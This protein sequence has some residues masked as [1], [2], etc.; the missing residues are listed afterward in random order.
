MSTKFD[1]FI[2]LAAMRTGSNLL[3][4][5]LNALDGVACHGEAFNP[6]F[7]GR[8]K[9]DELFGVSLEERDK[10]PMRL[11]DA[12]RAAP[13]ALNGFR[14]FQEHDPRVLQS[15]LDDPRC[16][17]IILSRN[18]LD[19]YVSLKI[20]RKTKQWQLTNIK[21]RKDAQIE[22][23]PVDFASY[24]DEQQE[25]KQ[26][27]QIHLQKTGQTAFHINYDDLNQLEILNGLSAWLG[28]GSRLDA[29]DDRLKPQNPAPAL[30]KVTNP[31]EMENALSKIDSF[32]LHRVPNFEPRRGPAVSRYI[33]APKTPLMYLPIR[34]GPEAV[35]AQWL[36]DLDT[37][38][39]RDLLTD[40]NRKQMR[41]WM[42]TNPGHRKFT[43]LRHPLARA[44][45]VFCSHILNKG[46]GAY[47]NIRNML[48][49]KYKIPFPGQ[50][51]KNNYS[52]EQHY[53]AFSAFLVFL[54]HI[55]AGQTPIRVDGLWCSQAS[56]LEGMSVFAMPDFILR[57]EEIETALPELARK[58]GHTNPPILG[59]SEADV[60]FLLPDIYDAELEA[61]ATE[62]YQRDYVLY[63]FKD[64]KPL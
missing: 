21:V 43:V 41:Q 1:Y 56:T 15:A 52:K 17:K 9:S 46:P 59:T 42:Q 60:P 40:R 24:L 33:A 10:D 3:E 5:N 28:V 19:S 55:L 63:G 39:A 23:D 36:A 35:V 50:I 27:L 48:R 49:N 32:N 44:H 54:R 51:R 8:L 30:S 20:A 38:D 47:L 4:A 31:V 16:A 18:P 2:V 25:F 37:M 45:S 64:W 14:Y 57:E 29:L 34:G 13:D 12:I 62:T 11:L 7:I 61:L 53:E 6:H 26:M 58:V 22:F